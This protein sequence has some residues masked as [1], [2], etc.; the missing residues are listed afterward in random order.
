MKPKEKILVATSG[1]VDSSTTAKLLQQDY[2]V[3]ACILKMHELAQKAID[4]CTNVCDAIG[5]PLIVKD[6]RGEFESIV[7]YN[8]YREYLDGR[9]PNPCVLCNRR[10][11]F[12][13]LFDIADELGIPYIASGH[14]ANVV[15]DETTQRYFITKA[16]DLHKDQTYMLWRLPQ[17][18]LKRIIFPLGGYHSKEDVRKY[19]KDADI[20]V[21]DKDD[22]QDICFIAD[23]DYRKF[24]REYAEDKGESSCIRMG[25]FVLDGKVLGKHNGTPFYTIGQRRGLGIAYK[26]PLYVK[27]IDIQD[28]VVEVATIED[29]YSN[30]LIA[31]DINIIKYDNELPNKEYIVKIR[32]KDNG[33]PAKCELRDNKIFVH[34]V[35]PC[36]SV[37][38]GQSVVIYDGNAMVAGGIISSTF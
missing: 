3:T 35:E 12:K 23:N 11:K 6:V 27:R 5:V 14:Y 37:A 33:K 1:G 2:E 17:E 15:F 30:G 38:L 24:I 34:F 9:T 20:P 19:A 25:D 7:K 28:N 4:D 21:A 22:S 10:V 29:T 16:L 32:Y 31:E 18:Y 26:K 13:T 8:F 36:S